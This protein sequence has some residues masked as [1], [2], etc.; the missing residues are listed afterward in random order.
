MTYISYGPSYSQS[1][2]RSYNICLS[3]CC[4]TSKI[5]KIGE[6]Q[7][8]ITQF[9]L[10]DFAHIPTWLVFPRDLPISKVWNRSDNICSS[11]HC[12]TSKMGKIGEI[13][14]QITQFRL[15]DFAHI[16][17]WL[18]FPRNLPTYKVWSRSDKICSSYCCNTSKMGKN[19][20]I[21][22]QITQFRLSN[23]A[24]I[25]TWPVFPRDLPISKLWN[26][27]DNICSSYHCNTSKMGKIEEIQGQITQFRLT[28]FAHIRNWLVFP[29]DLPIY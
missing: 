13:Q 15:T 27:S 16:R 28:D 19:E 17:T 11:Y 18:V 26:R 21:Q 20:E 3:Y 2:N 4:N 5:G 14:G 7:G 22:G 6:I 29:R 25:P 9:R 24:H 10:S 23:F 12:N 8:Q 1:L